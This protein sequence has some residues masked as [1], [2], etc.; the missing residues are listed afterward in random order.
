MKYF[1][2]IYVFIILHCIFSRNKS[3]V[4]TLSGVFM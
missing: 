4:E 1:V 2:F 3:H